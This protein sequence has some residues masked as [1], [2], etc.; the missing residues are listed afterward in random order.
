[1]LKILQFL[2]KEILIK[3]DY[4]G[5]RTFFNSWLNKN[6]LSETTLKL[7]KE[8]IENL[9]EPEYKS[10]YNKEGD[11]ILHIAVKEKNDM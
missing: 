3:S 6:K 5:I 1:M 11:T 2:L 10:F 4:E 7:F 8:E 9:W